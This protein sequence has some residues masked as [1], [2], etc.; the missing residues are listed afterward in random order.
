MIAITK[1]EVTV[2]TNCQVLTRY[3]DTRISTRSRTA[4]QSFVSLCHAYSVSIENIF[5]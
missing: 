4:E 3:I 5:M 1:F 2:A